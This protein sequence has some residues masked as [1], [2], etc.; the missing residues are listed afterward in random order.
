M[1]L[2][3]KGTYK[4]ISPVPGLREIGAIIKLTA[5]PS[6]LF[7]QL[8]LSKALPV[9]SA[10]VSLLIDTGASITSVDES[11]IRQMQLQAL[12]RMEVTGVSGVPEKRWLYRMC[13]E[14]TLQDD[15]I[16]IKKAL[17]FEV[18]VMGIPQMKDPFGVF[19]D[20]LF[21]LD[22]IKF[23]DFNYSGPGGTWELSLPI[24]PTDPGSK[25]K[26]KKKRT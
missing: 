24:L 25:K 2:K 20:G 13:L 14:I 6:I 1:T 10:E 11:I 18:V 4:A 15:A 12:G 17:N 9:P 19:S 16:G 26:N 5:K 21:G 8:L 3:Y 22:F 7:Q 23:F